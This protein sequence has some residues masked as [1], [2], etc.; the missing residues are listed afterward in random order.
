MTEL[1]KEKRQKIKSFI[2]ILSLVV[3]LIAPFGLYWSLN[4]NALFSQRLFFSLFL[5]GLI[6][7]GWA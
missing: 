2:Q 7:G 6:V 4:C 5:I 1:T 3:V